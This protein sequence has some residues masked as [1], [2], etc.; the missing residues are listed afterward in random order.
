RDRIMAAPIETRVCVLC[1]SS[2]SR[3]LIT[4]SGYNVARCSGCGLVFVSNP[5][6]PE[7]LREIYSFQSGYHENLAVEDDSLDRHRAA[8]RAHRL[9]LET[10]CRPG[11]LLDIGC[12]VGFFLR[13]AQSARWVAEGVEYSA[14]TADLARKRGLTVHVGAVDNVDLPDQSFDAITMWDVIEHMPAPLSALVAAR[15]LLKKGGI[16]AIETPNVDGLFPSISLRFVPVLRFWRHPEP[17][18]HLFQFSKTTLA[19]ALKQ[20]GYEIVRVRDDRIPI[21]YSFGGL[22]QIL[23][24]PKYAAYSATFIP[25]ALAGPWVRSGDTIQVLARRVD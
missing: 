25:L 14:D 5:P 19:R 4:K 23:R 6:T 17:P 22:R 24:S 12:S 20:T 8:A 11:R 2:D 18:S 3:L 1:G 15:R 21:S 10:A 16:L 13:E 9:F 7:Q